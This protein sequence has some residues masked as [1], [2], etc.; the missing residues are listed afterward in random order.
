MKQTTMVLT[1]RS[2]GWKLRE[3]LKFWIYFKVNLIGFT[4]NSMPNKRKRGS[5]RITS[6]SCP[7]Q[8]EW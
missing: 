8:Q 3:E 6:K 2:E 5:T 1:L 7:S 4:D